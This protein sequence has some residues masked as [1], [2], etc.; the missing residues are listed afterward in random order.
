MKKETIKVRIKDTGEIVNV[1]KVGENAYL[2]AEN[3]EVYNREDFDEVGEET[4]KNGFTVMS[5]EEFIN[6]IKS[7][8][9]EREKAAKNEFAKMMLSYEMSLTIEVVKKRPFMSPDRVYKKVSKIVKNTLER[10]D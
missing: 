1:E 2:D 7:L 10:L 9:G 4:P 5:P 6:N 3:K 8:V